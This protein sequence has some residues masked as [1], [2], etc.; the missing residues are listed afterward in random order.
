MTTRRCP[1]VS[2]IYWFALGEAVRRE[3]D[4]FVTSA[5]RAN[6]ER[7]ERVTGQQAREIDVKP[8]PLLA[9]LTEVD[10]DGEY[11]EMASA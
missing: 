7:L 1:L 6:V 11:L 2:A 8:G 10:D 5:S 3:L 4:G 9:R